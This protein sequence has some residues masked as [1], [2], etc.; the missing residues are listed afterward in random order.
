MNYKRILLAIAS[1]CFLVSFLNPF[2]NPFNKIFGKLEAYKAI[3]PPE[4]VYVHTDKAFYTNGETLWFKTYLVN[5]IDHLYSDKSKVVYVELL[6][7]KDSI[8]AQRKVYIDAIGAS[9]DIVLDSKLKQ[10][11][12]HLRA[13]TKYM[14]NDTN[15][16][17]FEKDIPIWHQKISQEEIYKTNTAKNEREAAVPEE[18]IL[19]KSLK[20]IK[21]KFN[22]YPEG[23]NLVTDLESTLGIKAEDEKGNGIELQGKIK[24]SQGNNVALFRTY[25][26]GLGKIQFTPKKGETYTAEI[27]GYSEE[28]FALPNALEKGYTLNIKNKADH[29]LLEVA[30]NIKYGLKDVLILGHMRGNTFFKYTEKSKN[31]QKYTAK[32]VCKEDLQDGVAHFTLFT[33]RGKPICERLTF[34]DNPENDI[35]L[36][37]KP[38]KNKYGLRDE[39]MLD[40]SILDNDKSPIEGD[41]SISVVN[42]NAKNKNGIQPANIE[43]W[44]L[45]DSDIGAT[46]SNPN[47]FFVKDKKEQRKYLL[48][49]LMLTHGWRRFLWTDFIKDQVDKNKAYEPEKGIMITGKTTE[50]KNKY[51]AKQ[52]IV[53]L[54]VLNNGVFQEK[55]RTNKQG[56]FNFGPYVFNDT[57]KA[58]VQAE[59][60][61]ESNVSIYMNS[62]SPFFK[63]DKSKRKKPIGV[64]LKI[65]EAYLEESRQKKILDFRYDPLSI[66]LETVEIEGKVKTRQEVINEEIRELTNTYG[67]PSDRLFTDSIPGTEA[68]SAIDLL[69]RVG[70][71]SIRGSY[72]NQKIIIRGTSSF[73]ASTDPLFLIDGNEVPGDVFSA[74]QANEISFLDVL[75]GVDAAVYGTRGANGVVAAYTYNFNRFYDREYPGVTDFVVEGFYTAKEFFKPNYNIEKIKD[76]KPDYRTTL[77]WEPFLKEKELSFFTGD[78]QGK[79]I[80]NIE[81]IT[82]QGQPIKGIYEF[83]VI[84]NL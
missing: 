14:L 23:G 13:Y 76:N 73:V 64:D 70:G 26:F 47:Y 21:P 39:V 22:F 35:V 2:E 58:V 65:A 7:I 68:A 81:G 38:N 46:I 12:Y 28:K 61:G 24:D 66:E 40:V 15:P 52:S 41:F 30:T 82:E 80:I 42:E 79:F 11:N 31:K 44:L 4:K 6:D 27:N 36:N 78:Q 51:A 29:I 57:I 25:K 10:G 19:D 69:R 50:R 77:H 54:N 32:L 9:G 67:V 20:V 56:K 34:I 48:D 53:T 84:D 83:D 75:K 49:A 5:G 55:K 16:I 3:N 71:V 8:V 60:G 17:V 18:K 62:S 59:S 45:L 43:S 63:L 37:I 72:P 74:L 1:F 33:P